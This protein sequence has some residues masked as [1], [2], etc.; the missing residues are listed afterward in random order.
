MAHPCEFFGSKGKIVG[1][2]P[3]LMVLNHPSIACFFSHCGWNSSTEGL[4]SGVPP[5]LILLTIRGI[6]SSLLSCVSSTVG[7]WD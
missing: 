7:V 6:R 2:T 5:G 3:Q 1:W 4:S